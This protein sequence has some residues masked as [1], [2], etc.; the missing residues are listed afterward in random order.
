M[1]GALALAVSKSV[2]AK[3]I[4]VCDAFAEK[5]EAF[6]KANGVCVSNA[7]EIAENCDYIFLGV[8][9]QSFEELFAEISPILKKRTDGFVLVSMAAGISISAVEGLADCASAPARG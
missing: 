2:S 9:P 8:K 3:E 7:K 4:A 5:A 6:A 1:G